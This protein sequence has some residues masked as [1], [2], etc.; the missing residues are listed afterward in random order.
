MAND[1]DSIPMLV[2]MVTRL[3]LAGL[4]SGGSD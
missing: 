4:R 2:K 1:L 3:C